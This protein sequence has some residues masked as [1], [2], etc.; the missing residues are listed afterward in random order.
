MIFASAAC[1]LVRGEGAAAILSLRAC[2]RVAISGDP[3]PVRRWWTVIQLALIVAL[4][5]S[6]RCSRRSPTGPRRHALYQRRSVTNPPAPSCWPRRME[7]SP[8]GSPPRRVT[9]DCWWSRRSSGRAAGPKDCGR[10]SR[11]R[12][13]GRRLSV[14]PPLHSRLL[15]G[16]VCDGRPAAAGPSDSTVAV[17]SA[18]R[19][20]RT[21]RARRGCLW[22][23]RRRPITERSTRSSPTRASGRAPRRSSTRRITRSL[24]TSSLPRPRRGRVDHH[25]Q[26]TLGPAAGGHWQASAQT[27]IKPIAPYWAPKVQDATILGSATVD[28]HRMWKI[29]FADPQTPGSSRS[30]STSRMSARSSSI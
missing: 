11:S 15:S 26:Q 21:A 3:T 7:S 24:L 1:A 13:D 16:G 5:G 27:P 28:G 4:W 2:S 20:P 10:G 22:C 9:G 8:S 29:A 18:L 12:V 14:G 30:G 6:R 23:G 25:R 19:C 17:A